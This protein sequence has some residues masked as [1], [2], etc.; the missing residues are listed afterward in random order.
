MGKKILGT[1]GLVTATVWIQRR[2]VQSR[3][4]VLTQKLVKL[5]TK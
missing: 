2:V 1:S 5:K 4:Q 3:K